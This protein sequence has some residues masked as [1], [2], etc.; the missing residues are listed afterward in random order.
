MSFGP[1]NAFGAF[2]P[3]VAR[4]PR[5]VN[6]SG[7][8]KDDSKQSSISGP[9]PIDHPI[10]PSFGSW[11]GDANP[12]VPQSAST[13]QQRSF[14]SILSPS[15]PTPTARNNGLD[16]QQDPL[17]KPFVYTREF[18]LSLYDHD[19]ATKRPIELAV[20]DIATK[21]QGSGV[22]KPWALS[23]WRDGEKELFSTS[24]HPPASRVRSQHGQAR[25]SSTNVGD[26][27]SNGHG[28]GAFGS[29]PSLSHRDIPGGG[30]N[31]RG[32]GGESNTLDLA[33]L[34]AL[35]RE[36]D[37]A[38]ASPSLSAR[39]TGPLASPGL[40]TAEKER[41]LAAAR[42]T[43]VGERPSVERRGFLGVCSAALGV[44]GAPLWRRGRRPERV[45]WAERM[46]GRVG[47]GGG[48][49][50]PRRMRSPR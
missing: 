30:I 3:T 29:S 28:G 8:F 9:A 42:R 49:A 36:R 34:G 23:E 11:S 2:A 37:R 15:L 13:E 7:S 48:R 22:N 6:S 12:A 1:G 17:A 5:R 26:R 16:Q 14:S 18:L 10:T 19:K 33:S 21:E 40:T 46:F 24:I 20:N 31:G 32:G 25:N 38:L 35:P 44:R 47:G 43:R 4:P 39:S 50:V 27:D 41:D 45:E